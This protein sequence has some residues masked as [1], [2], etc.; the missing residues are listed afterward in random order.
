M[1]VREEIHPEGSVIRGGKT[2]VAPQIMGLC[3]FLLH[4]V[5]L[6]AKALG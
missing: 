6:G 5:G 3:H 2:S 4:R 1:G